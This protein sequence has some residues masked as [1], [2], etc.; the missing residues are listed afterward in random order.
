M[1]K[2]LAVEAIFKVVD[3]ASAPLKK[4]S[5]GIGDFQSKLLSVV[6]GGKA[7]SGMMNSIAGQVAI[8][9]LAAKGFS[10]AWGAVKDTVKSIPEFA[11]AAD[12]IGKTAQILGI[13]VE[14][15]QRFQ[16]AA[17]MSN[18][19][20]EDLSKS[21]ATLNKNMGSGALLT[22]LDKLDVGLSEQLRTAKSTEQAF[23]IITDAV[24]GYDDVAH[25]TA[26]LNATLGKSAADMIPML[27][28][29]SAGLRE[30]MELAPNVLSA[31]VIAQATVFG[32]TLTHIQSVLK[33]FTD[34]A[35]SGVS[36]RSSRMSLL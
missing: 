6:P 22:S 4:L 5:G 12:E 17:S 21:F 25:R 34:T 30:M 8:G 29:G 7:L 1:S 36:R 10:A 18:I 31:R 33:D 24:A 9:T 23:M 32:D 14:S 13:G 19:S 16:Y 15:L 11:A 35:K 27:A 3:G 20:N 28:D 26:V 2:S